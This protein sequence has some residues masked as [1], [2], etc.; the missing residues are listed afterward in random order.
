MGDDGVVRVGWGDSRTFA[1]VEGWKLV[2]RGS[3]MV[4]DRVMDI[5]FPLLSTSVFT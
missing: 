4:M 5:F 3:L 1:L 2:D